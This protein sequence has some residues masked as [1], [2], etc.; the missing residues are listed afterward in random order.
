MFF[1]QKT[2][3]HLEQNCVTYIQHLKFSLNLSFI[4]FKGSIQAICHAIIPSIFEKSS[5]ECAQKIHDKLRQNGC[6]KDH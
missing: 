2:K 5:T 6:Y 3:N 1:F 4:F